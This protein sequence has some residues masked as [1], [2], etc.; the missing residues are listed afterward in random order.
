MKP[1]FRTLGVTVLLG[2]VMV[3]PRLRAQGAAQMGDDEGKRYT[4]LHYIWNHGDKADTASIRA[5]YR[6]QYLKASGEFLAR[7]PRHPDLYLYRALAALELNL[8]DI[9]QQAGE[10]L[11]A[12]GFDTS[13]DP[14]IQRLFAELNRRGWYGTPVPQPPPRSQVAQSHPP[15]PPPG[16]PSQPPPALV[17]EKAPEPM[18]ALPTP[19]AFESVRGKD[20]RTA[21]AGTISLL[22]CEPG[23]FKMGDKQ[24]GPIT[25]VH[26][27]HGFWLGKYVVT[28]AQFQALMGS[29]PSTFKDQGL[30]APVDCVSWKIA[31]LFCR[32]LTQAERQ[33]GRVP[34]GYEYRLP[35]EA[36]WEYACRAGTTSDFVDGVDVLGLVAWYQPNSGGHTHPVGT[37]EANAWGFFDMHGNVWEWCHD[38]YGPYTGGEVTDPLGALTGTER[39]NRGGSWQNDKG[40]LR[41]ARRHA[42]MPTYVH[43]TNGFRVALAPVIPDD[44]L[45]L[46]AT[47]K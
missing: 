40:N 33:A 7:Y 20:I 31:D 45:A 10:H 46:T 30:N 29:N 38:W 43:R 17:E 8:A 34:V 39:V 21:A 4:T 19:P 44:R 35:T 28:Q 14:S 32:R 37:K 47:G 41:S 18:M 5:Q 23:T 36:E 25:T 13:T 2:L 42:G 15:S 11:K 27:T 22:W 12:A 6:L 16:P 9:G 1:L 26:L 24:V 3:A